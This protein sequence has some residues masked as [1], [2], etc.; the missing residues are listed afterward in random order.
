LI[1]TDLIKA[2]VSRVIYAHTDKTGRRTY[3]LPRALADVAQALSPGLDLT[4]AVFRFAK[5]LSLADCHTVER[6]ALEF[7]HDEAVSFARKRMLANGL[8]PSAH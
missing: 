5:A 4:A 1:L 8:P 2:K 3:A 7:S 6:L